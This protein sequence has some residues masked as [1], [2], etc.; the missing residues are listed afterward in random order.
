VH[1]VRETF[2]YTFPGGIID[3]FDEDVLTNADQ[4]VL[5][6]IQ[7]HCTDACY[8]QN[9]NSIDTVMS[10]FTVGSPT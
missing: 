2:Q 9:Q 5:Y 6:L 8:S 1:G 10:S 3:T 4:T 7:V